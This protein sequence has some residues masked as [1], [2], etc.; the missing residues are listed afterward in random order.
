MRC[1]QNMV[2]HEG[3]ELVVRY[4]GLLSESPDANLVEEQL[5]DEDD[6]YLTCGILEH[7]L[8]R[9]ACL[10]CGHERLMGFNYKRRF[11]GL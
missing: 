1:V 5:V 3:F 10:A 8:L 6:E 2:T 9:L 7:E 11:S 4:T